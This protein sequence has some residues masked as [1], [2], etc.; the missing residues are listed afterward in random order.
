MRVQEVVQIKNE[1]TSSKSEA[2]QYMTVATGK[3][4]PG[5]LLICLSKYI[6]LPVTFYYYII[7]CE[8]RSQQIVVTGIEK[9]ICLLSGTVLLQI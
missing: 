7:S 5:V 3:A 6:N 1:Q 9:I 8:A 4:R 2:N